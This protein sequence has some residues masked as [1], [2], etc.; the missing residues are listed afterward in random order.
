V[1]GT[2]VVVTVLG[3]VGMALL[4]RPGPDGP[5]HPDAWDPQVAEIAAFVEVERGLTFDEPVFVDFL[6][7]DEYRAAVTADEPTATA[8]DKALEDEANDQFVG[9]LRALGLLEGE[10]DMDQASDDL[11]DSG[12][13]AYYDPETERITVRGTVMT[14][15][16]RV[17][18]AHELTHALQDQHFDLTRMYEMASV[19]AEDFRAVIEGDAQRVES[20][21]VENELDAEETTAYE[22]ESQT[23]SDEGE[24]ATAESVPDIVMTSFAS[25]YIL[26]GAFIELLFQL[27]GNAGVDRALETPPASDV[28][29]FDPFRFLSPTDPLEV[30][31]PE[32]VNGGEVLDEGEFGATNLYLLLASRIDAGEALAAV[33]GWGGDVMVL[34]ESDG[35]ICMQV[36]VEGTTAETTLQLGAALTRW[37]EAMPGDADRVEI[38]DGGGPVELTACDPGA[39]APLAVA[40]DMTRALNLPSFRTYMAAQ[41]IEF[42]GFREAEADCAGDD[43]AT[44]VDLGKLDDWGALF[45]DP[46]FAQTFEQVLVACDV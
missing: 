14:P 25:P 31:A 28:Q 19:Q 35:E 46:A 1:V 42:R 8:E 15:G 7:P 21:Y 6:T 16:L 44:K 36:A 13:L 10:P 24:A 39:E 33:D 4:V 26:G 9:S 29:L 2:A 5:P 45:A 27:E 20:V 30:D 38:G 32:P 18:L 22:A 40:P 37:S 23:A 17:T 11:S 41:T 43:L 12:T 3:L 34:S